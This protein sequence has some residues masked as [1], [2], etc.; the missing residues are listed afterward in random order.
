MQITESLQYLHSKDIIHRDLK[1]SN[2]LITNDGN[3]AIL[4]DFGQSK[5]VTHNSITQ[6]HQFG[7]PLFKDP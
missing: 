7:T 2:I 1:P 5:K 6:N 4:T 3:N